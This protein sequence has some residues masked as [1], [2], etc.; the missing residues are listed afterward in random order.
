MTM[1]TANP[2]PV[3]STP[4][5]IWA[6]GLGGLAWNAYGVVQ[7]ASS[8]RSTPE[9]LMA[10][11]LDATQAMTMTSHP[12]WMTAAFA[13]GVFGGLAGSALLLL[14]RAAALPVFAVSLLAY[15]ALYV[16]DITKGV[17]AAMGTGQVA[18]LTFVVL[19][20]AGLLGAARRATAR[21]LLA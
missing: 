2:F 11:D 21:G 12:L 18:I 16:G 15:V 1:A 3:A 13:I 10:L 9:S 14:R 6:A 8:V 19:I 20:A 17:F 7:F 5:W 4:A